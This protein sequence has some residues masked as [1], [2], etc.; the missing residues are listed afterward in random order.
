MPLGTSSIAKAPLSASG[1]HRVLLEH[2]SAPGWLAK[3]LKRGPVLVEPWCE[4]LADLSVQL[5][6]DDSGHRNLG[7]TR[8]W[9]TSG[10]VYRG[11]VL[12]PWSAGLRPDL[13]RAL[14]GGGRGSQINDALTVMARFV[15]DALWA[16]GIRGPVGIDCMVIAE[17]GIPKL[18][19]VLEVNPRTTMGR[20]AMGIHRSTGLRG[21]WFHLDDR[22]L[23]AAGYADR[24]AFIARVE[25]ANGV[26]FTT[27][28]TRASRIL[29][30]MAVAKNTEVARAAWT[31]LGMTW[32]D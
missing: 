16:Q 15:G 30:V 32:P 18:F 31:D 4:R 12:G 26:Y 2:P 8:F 28:P 3:Q 24:D 6:L 27:D 11:S 19:P 1:Q 17:E 9:T 20:V 22:A 13:L 7:V 10:G 23:N 29:T 25:A 5:E 21:G 14:H